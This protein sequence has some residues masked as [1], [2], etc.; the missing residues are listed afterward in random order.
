MTPLCGDDVCCPTRGR[1]EAEENPTRNLVGEIQGQNCSGLS[2]DNGVSGSGMC[3]HA[4][5]RAHVCACVPCACV[6]LCVHTCVHYVVAHALV[7]VR[8]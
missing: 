1:Q 6:C 2:L 8:V 7:C 5:V 3:A 4:C